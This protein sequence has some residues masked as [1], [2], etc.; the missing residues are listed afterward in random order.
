[1]IGLP[2]PGTTEPTPISRS[3]GLKQGIGTQAVSPDLG[4]HRL[5][6]TVGGVDYTGKLW[7]RDDRGVLRVETDV[8]DRSIY[9]E[10]ALNTEAGGFVLQ[11]QDVNHPN[12]DPDE[13]RFQ[14]DAPDEIRSIEHCSAGPCV[15]VEETRLR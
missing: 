15:P 6:W 10:I 1:M 2:E 9:Q 8:L 5:E 4:V 13:F 3:D 14:L 12:Y 11:G 7:M